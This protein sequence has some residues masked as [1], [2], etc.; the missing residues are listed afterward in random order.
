MT[1]NKKYVTKTVKTKRNWAQNGT[2]KK[3][4][5]KMLLKNG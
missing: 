5:I 1:P 3:T 4:K 2:N